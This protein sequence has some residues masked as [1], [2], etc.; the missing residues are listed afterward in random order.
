MRH[1]ATTELSTALWQ[2]RARD[3]VAI[4]QG[5]EKV[6]VMGGVEVRVGV[7]VGVG[8]EV[9]VVVVVVVVV[10]AVADG[11]VQVWCGLTR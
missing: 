4:R 11:C 3:T 5:V 8:V 10:V 2:C 1:D 6:V 7:G 9:Q